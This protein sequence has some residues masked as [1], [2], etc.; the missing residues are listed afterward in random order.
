MSKFASFMKDRKKVK[1]NEKHA[2]TRFLCDEKGNPLLWEF[3]HITSKENEEL[4]E[5]CM[6]E[7]PVTGKPGMYRPRLRTN[8]YIRR[9]ITASV[10]FPDLYDAG[11]QDS[12]GVKTP[13]ELLQAMVDEPGEYSDLAA[14]VQKLQGFDVSFEE[15]VEEAKN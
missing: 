13:E 5:G 11:L 6:V 8:E 4:R 3:R 15:K 1:E 9:M 7:V 10:V 12:Y 2:V 14:Y